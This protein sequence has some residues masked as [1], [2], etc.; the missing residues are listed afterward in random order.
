MGHKSCYQ[1]LKETYPIPKETYQILNG[2]LTGPYKDPMGQ[3]KSV[4]G[5][6]GLLGCL[7]WSQARWI[8][9]KVNFGKVDLKSADL[10]ELS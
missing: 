6:L 8:F 5:P 9:Q 4:L 10:H 1:I 7:C 2:A 3:K